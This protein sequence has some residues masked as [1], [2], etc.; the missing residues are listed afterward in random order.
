LDSYSNLSNTY[1]HPQYAIDTNEA[2][3]FLGGSYL[4]QLDEIEVF[5]KK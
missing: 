5:Q 1:S 2:M 3:T 4:F